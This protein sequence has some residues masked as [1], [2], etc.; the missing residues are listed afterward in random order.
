MD[1]RYVLESQK[2]KAYGFLGQTHHL[3]L[4]T[5][6]ERS[7]LEPVPTEPESNEISAGS[8]NPLASNMLLSDSRRRF[9]RLRPWKLQGLQHH[10]LPC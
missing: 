5:Q 1:P 6:R 3:Q 4:A 2:S 9:H 7:E 8:F 10:R